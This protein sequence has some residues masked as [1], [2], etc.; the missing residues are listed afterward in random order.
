MDVFLLQE[1]N[2]RLPKAW[3]CVCI[4]VQSS[5]SGRVWVGSSHALLQAHAQILVKGGPVSFCLKVWSLKTVSIC[6]GRCEHR[7]QMLLRCMHKGFAVR[8][9]MK[10]ESTHSYL[11][12]MMSLDAVTK[13][14]EAETA[15]ADFMIAERW[16]AMLCFELDQLRKCI[17]KSNQRFLV[18]SAVEIRVA[19]F[20]VRLKPNCQFMGACYTIIHLACMHRSLCNFVYKMVLGPF[21]SS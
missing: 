21:K 2:P 7:N 16:A 4:A 6:R 9:R 10:L 1:V 3:G 20:Q 5:W 12:R 18:M 13:L 8:F 11:R 15:L 14:L 19:A 17:L